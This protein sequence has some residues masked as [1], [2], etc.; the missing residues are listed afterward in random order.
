MQ[1]LHNTQRWSECDPFAF[2]Q[3]SPDTGDRGYES[4]AVYLNLNNYFMLTAGKST[5]VGSS[6]VLKWRSSLGRG[7]APFCSENRYTLCP[8]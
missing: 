7:G 4:S 3:F 2:S 8:F 1:L 6:A 5:E